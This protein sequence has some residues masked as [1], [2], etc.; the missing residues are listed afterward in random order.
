MELKH[1]WRFDKMLTLEEAKAKAEQLRSEGKKIVSMNGSFDLLQAG[2]LDFIEEAKMQGDVLFVGVN[3]DESVRGGKGPDRP[4]IPQQE[5]MALLAAMEAVDYVV[6]IE[7]AYTEEPQ[8]SFI[9]AI[10]PHVHVNGSDYGP[11]ESWI[12][13]PA[14]Q[15]VGAVGYKVERRPNLSTSEII[16]KIKALTD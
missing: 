7:G 12:E 6:L 2:H 9:P 4:I 10:K 8:G 14:M 1:H 11:V 15:E 16:A 3:S 13:W 5:R